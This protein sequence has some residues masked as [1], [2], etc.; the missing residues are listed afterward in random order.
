MQISGMKNFEIQ[1]AGIKRADVIAINTV[2]MQEFF[3]IKFGHHLTH[4]IKTAYFILSDKKFEQLEHFIDKDTVK[5][6]KKRHGIDLNR[7]IITLGYNGSPK[8]R[9]IEI[10]QILNALDESFKNKIHVVIPL[11]YGLPADDSYLKSIEDMCSRVDFST[12]LILEYLKGEALSE[13][14]IA[15]EVFLNLRETDCLNAAMIET[16][17][18]GNIVINGSWLPYGSLRRRGVYFKEIE[19]LEDLQLVIPEVLNNLSEER[20]EAVNNRKILKEFFDSRRLAKDW[21]SVYSSLAGA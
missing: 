20:N 2:E 4:K 5:G 10:L 7:T 16:L 1:Y 14:T 17:Y 6:Y 19:R 12:E 11:A 8:Q 9:H 13:F 3:K 15:S 18:S 21:E